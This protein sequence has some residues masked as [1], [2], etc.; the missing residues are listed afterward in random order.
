MLSNFILR[1]V[2]DELISKIVFS[3]TSEHRS[4]Y[5]YIYIYN[6]FIKNENNLIDN[7]YHLCLLSPRFHVSANAN[8]IHKRKRNHHQ[9]LSVIMSSVFPCKPAFPC[10]RQ[11]QRNPQ[12]QTQYRKRKTNK[13][14]L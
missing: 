4:I 12:T 2:F 9:T 8:V 1:H 3:V 6:L 7:M 5:I 11:R 13:Y 10:V 14:L